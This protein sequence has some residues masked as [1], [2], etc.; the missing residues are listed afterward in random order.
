MGAAAVASSKNEGGGHSIAG[1]GKKRPA[2]LPRAAAV[3]T[4]ALSLLFAGLTA[5]A[6]HRSAAG[7]GE[8]LSA[9]VRRLAP[10]I[11]TC[12]FSSCYGQ[13]HPGKLSPSPQ[14]VDKAS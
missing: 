8:C 14:E 1:E 5:W 10:L 9:V 11:C 7:D 12:L 3:A 6:L 2:A 13:R 4:C